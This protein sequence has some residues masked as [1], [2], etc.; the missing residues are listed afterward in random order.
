MHSKLDADMFG[1]VELVQAL[2]KVD[3]LTADIQDPE[4]ASQTAKE[5]SGHLVGAYKRFLHFIAETGSTVQYN[6]SSP[7]RGAQHREISVPQ[8]SILYERLQAQRELAEERAT[9]RGVFVRANVES[10]TWAVR[11]DA[12]RHQRGRI[13]AGSDVSL[14]GVV[15]DTQR[16]E[17]ECISRIEETGDGGLTSGLEL[18]VLRPL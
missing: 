16:Y 4:R 11:D 17:L 8:A 15:L 1:E 6:W 5:N 7:N 18:T 13:A 14:S 12:G 2:E 3:E 10:G 9:L